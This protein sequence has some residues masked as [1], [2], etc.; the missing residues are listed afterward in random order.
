MGPGWD[1]TGSAP[2][3][4][5]LGPAHIFSSNDPELLLAHQGHVNM[6]D[7]HVEY[8]RDRTPPV[9]MALWFS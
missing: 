9:E 2:G 3:F 8:F 5:N 4:S 6:A 7:R 1:C